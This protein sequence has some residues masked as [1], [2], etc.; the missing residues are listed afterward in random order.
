ME[1]LW[2]ILIVVISYLLGAIPTAYLVIRKKTGGD[3]RDTGTGN[4]GAMN[5]ARAT[6]SLWYFALTWIIDMAK[7]ALAI[8]ISRW[9]A[10]LGYSP[11]WGLIIAVMGIFLGHNW[12]VFLK[13]SGGKGISCLMGT[14][15]VLEPLLLFLPWGLICIISIL[16][17]KR[18]FAGQIISIISLPFLG[19]F[20]APYLTPQPEWMFSIQYFYLILTLVIAIPM[21]IRHAP[22]IKPLLQGKEPRWYW[23]ER[24]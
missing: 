19:Y 10:F 22:R 2:L 16:A 4:I 8:F 23:K 11:D 6:E 3:I 12:S 7:A 20:L 21:F 14:L 18:L 1:N 17:T 9:L 24:G 13:F 15:L 5:V